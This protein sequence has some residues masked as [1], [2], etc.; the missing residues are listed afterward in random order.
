MKHLFLTLFLFIGIAVSAQET[1]YNCAGAAAKTFTATPSGGTAPYTFSWTGP[2][3]FTASTSAISP[4]TA[5]VYTWTITDA[6]GCTATGTHTLVIEA[7]PT[8]GITVNANNTCTGSSQTI[9]AT[10]VPAGYTYSW[11]FGSGASPATSTSASTSVS[12]STS[13][14]KTI[15][16]TISKTFSGSTN[17]CSATCTWTKTKTITITNLTGSSSCS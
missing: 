4:T 2:G 17:G 16:L 11:D 13:G 12:Y 14:T 10:G 5:G 8:A 9:D 1:S 6:S 15:T 7:D 3:G